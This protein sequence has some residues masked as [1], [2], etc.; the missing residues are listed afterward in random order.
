MSVIDLSKMTQYRIMQR[1]PATLV[2]QS[3]PQPLKLPAR[4]T[5]EQIEEGRQWMPAFNSE[6][7]LAVIVQD[8]TMAEVLMLGWTNQHALRHTIETGYA[9]YWSRSRRQLWRKG[10]HSGQAQRV[11]AILIDD[12]QDCLLFKVH[13]TGGAS[14]HV[15]YRS[16]F[17]RQLEW[18]AH[19]TDGVLRFLETT[20]VYD[21][22][23]VYGNATTETS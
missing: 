17:F 6:G 20:K 12:D 1:S 5:V 15:G 3:F 22:A 19:R 8:A 7:L 13:L 10:E 14:C 4:G 16:C 11:A 2:E 21:P 18:H 9:H 23:T